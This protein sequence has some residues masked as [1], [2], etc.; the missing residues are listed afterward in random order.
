ML[1]ILATADLPVMGPAW[2]R[3]WSARW[4][5]WAATATA[6]LRFDA[7]DA[8]RAVSTPTPPPVALAALDRWAS[9]GGAG[10]PRFDWSADT[11]RRRMSESRRLWAAANLF[12]STTGRRPDWLPPT[13]SWRRL[14]IAVIGY[15]TPE[16]RPSSRRHTRGLR[17]GAGELALHEVL[18]EVK[19]RVPTHHPARARRATCDSVVCDGELM[20]WP[21]SW[22]AAAWTWCSP[23][24]HAGGG[25]SRGRHA[26][27]GARR[28]GTLVVVD[29]IRTWPAGGAAGADQRV[30]C[31]SRPHRVRCGAGP[32]ACS[33]EAWPNSRPLLREGGASA[34]GSLVAEARRNAAR[35]DF[36]LVRARRGPTCP[37]VPSPTPASRPWSPP[38]R[39]FSC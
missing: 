16:T 31:W 1:R 11:L 38:P 3:G 36:G 22:E 12:D 8:L 19:R 26:G 4:T 29:V 32:T 24:T 37:R 2:P 17:F 23:A 30:G 15:I 20:S 39:I 27:D 21:G 6:P 35:A 7:G 9:G 28:G 33:S 5:A 13:A 10:R 34:V 18:A 14:R 25:R